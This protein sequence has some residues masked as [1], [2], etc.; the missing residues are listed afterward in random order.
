MPRN[1][2]EIDD[3]RERVEARVR[4]LLKKTNTVATLD[5]IKDY[6][7]NQNHQTRPRVWLDDMVELFGRACDVVDLDN[8]ELMV[9][10]DAWNYFPHSSLNGRSPA[11]VFL[12]LS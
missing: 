2:A 5:D 6:I 4:S 9:F 1:A 10:Q 8:A 11:E 7:F 12:E 3:F